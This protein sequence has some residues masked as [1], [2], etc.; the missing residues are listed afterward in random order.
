[1]GQQGYASSISVLS[2]M[3]PER[4]VDSRYHV[5]RLPGQ[6]RDSPKRYIKY[7]VNTDLFKINATERIWYVTTELYKSIWC[8]S[9]QICIKAFV[10]AWCLDPGTHVLS[11]GHVTGF[12]HSRS[13]FCHCVS[14]RSRVRSAPRTLV[15][16]CFV[17]LHAVCV[18]IGCVH[19]CCH[20]LCEHVAYEFSH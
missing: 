12:G 14:A 5:Y 19:L 13:I 8:K 18:S 17:V 15:H 3:V 4:W 11:F 16:V 9:I 10:G 7:Q 2:Q 1:M 6:Q 20:V